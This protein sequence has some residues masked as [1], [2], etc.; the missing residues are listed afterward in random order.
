MVYG[1]VTSSHV[2]LQSVYWMEQG[3]NEK[4][5]GFTMWLEE[6]LSQVHVKFPQLISEP[7]VEWQLRERLFYGMSKPLRNRLPYIY[8]DPTVT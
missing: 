5:Q 6:A 1:I 3:K 2:L 7:E 4:V 8:N